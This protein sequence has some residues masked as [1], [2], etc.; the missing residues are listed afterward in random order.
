MQIPCFF[1][2]SFCGVTEIEAE[3]NATRMKVL[4]VTDRKFFAWKITPPFQCRPDE[5]RRER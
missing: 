4:K 1:S 3:I 2:E 5:L